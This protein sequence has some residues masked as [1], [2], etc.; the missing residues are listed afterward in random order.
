M[1]QSSPDQNLDPA[2]LEKL[3]DLIAREGMIDRAKLT[4]DST[5]ESLGVKSPDLLV[6]LMAVEE[7]FGVYI[8][9]DDA[10]SEARTLED[11]VKALSVHLQKAQT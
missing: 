10:L 9:V 3:L 2:N 5:L 6:V 1:L 7:Q 8:P 4:M 11:L